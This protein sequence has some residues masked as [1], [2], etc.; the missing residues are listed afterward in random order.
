MNDNSEEDHEKYGHKAPS[1]QSGD[2][3]TDEH[4][5]EYAVLFTNDGEV[6]LRSVDGG[7]Q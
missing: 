3:L 4:G 5:N 6:E 1:I 7:H 2:I